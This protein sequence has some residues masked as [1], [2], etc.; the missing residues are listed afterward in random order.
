MWNRIRG[1]LTATI[2]LA[3][4]YSITV[5]GS[6]CTDNHLKVIVAK[7]IGGCHGGAM[8]KTNGFVCG[9]SSCRKLPSATRSH[10][11]TQTR[12]EGFLGQF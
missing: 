9:I 2:A 11:C 12:V 5:Q 4:P 6:H 3:A 10:S 8:E 7:P 1:S